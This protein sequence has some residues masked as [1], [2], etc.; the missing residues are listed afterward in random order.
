MEIILIIFGI[1]ILILCIETYILHK[2]LSNAY[3]RIDSIDYNQLTKI[4]CKITDLE[5]KYIGLNC[6]IKNIDSSISNHSNLFTSLFNLLKIEKLY[7]PQPLLS[8]KRKNGRKNKR[9]S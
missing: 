3:E 6:H 9:T 4:N 1:I 8:F 2:S 7:Y 5:I